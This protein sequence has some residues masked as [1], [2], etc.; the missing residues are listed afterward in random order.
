M[1][2]FAGMTRVAFD[3]EWYRTKWFTQT[4]VKNVFDNLL[5]VSSYMIPLIPIIF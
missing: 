5:Q 4:C 3:H 1:Y 2:E